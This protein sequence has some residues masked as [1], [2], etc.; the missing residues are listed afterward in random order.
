MLSFVLLNSVHSVQIFLSATAEEE[1]AETSIISATME[2][3]TAKTAI[4]SA[5]SSEK[6]C[7]DGDHL[8]NHEGFLCFIELF[9]NCLSCTYIVD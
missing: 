3:K 1:S 8:G 5:T 4:I 6:N 9:F 7:G 2:E